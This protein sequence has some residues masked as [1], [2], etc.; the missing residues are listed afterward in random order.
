MT[1]Y[2]IVPR[3]HLWIGAAMK[4]VES[5]CANY[6]LGDEMIW[7]LSTMPELMAPFANVNLS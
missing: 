2:A 1:L 5:A 7:T 6:K 4:V 3:A